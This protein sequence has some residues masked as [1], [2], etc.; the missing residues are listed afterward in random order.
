MNQATK[1][2][3]I[4]TRDVYIPRKRVSIYSFNLYCFHCISRHCHI[5]V[6][7][8]VKVDEDVLVPLLN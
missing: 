5:H 4:N 7:M 1:I 2:A 8:V 6:D 3:L